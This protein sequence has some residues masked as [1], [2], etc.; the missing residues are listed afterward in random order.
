MTPGGTGFGEEGKIA[1]GQVIFCA[2]PQY[3]S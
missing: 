2:A 3:E 1:A